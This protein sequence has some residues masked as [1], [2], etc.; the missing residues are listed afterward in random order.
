[1]P[2]L[3]KSG[4]SGSE[5]TH[6]EAELKVSLPKDYKNFL[7]RMNGLYLTDPDFC[8]LPFPAVDEGYIVFD[9]F[10]GLIPNEESNDLVCFNKEFSE[11][12]DFLKKV[13]VIGEDG[14]GNPY[15]ILEGAGHEGVY[16]WDRTHLHEGEA[17][18]AFDIQEQMGSGNLFYAAKNFH[19]FYSLIIKKLGGGVKYIQEN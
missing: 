9:R 2:I 4:L 3:Y 5:I 17:S 6:V 13:I 10:F 16:Y 18:N 11:E 7:S 1:M 15:V 12:L 8:E 14:G 19:E